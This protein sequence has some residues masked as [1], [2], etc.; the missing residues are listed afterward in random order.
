M[1]PLVVYVAQVEITEASGMG[2]VAWH[3]RREFERRG[4]EFLHIGGE[5]AGRLAHP[6][7]FPYAAYRAYRRIGRRAALVLVHEPASG[8]FARRHLPAVVFSHGVERRGWNLALQGRDGNEGG[9]RRRTKLLFPVWRLRQCDKGL[10]KASRLLLIN[11]EDAA[12]A[13]EYYRREGARVRVFRN[14]VY[15]STLSERAQPREQTILFVGSWL[16]RKGIRTLVEAARILDERGARPR[17][18]LAGTNAAREEVLR[19]WPERLRS[20]VEVVSRFDR[21]TE[22]N[23][24]ARASVFVL[25]SFFEGQPLSLLQA[26]ETGR[27]CITTDCCGQ[28]DLI[29]DGRNGLLHEPGDARRL[30]SLITRCLEE[31]ELR[32]T[33]GANAKLSVA[34]R[35][36]EVVSSEIADFAEEALRE[37]RGNGAGWSH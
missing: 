23:L 5:Q 30:A 35:S 2:R 25:P 37:S 18:L 13:R 6:G 17:W 28:R 9:I 8:V 15:A 24:F 34:G 11:G 29:Q 3:W 22:E 19:R 27:C 1:K 20:S 26:M 33:L 31:E 21:E 12:F 16:E 10:R 4:Y 32:L 36:W 7:L 14:G